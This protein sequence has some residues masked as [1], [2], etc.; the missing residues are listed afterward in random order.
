MASIYISN[1]KYTKGLSQ[2]HQPAHNN[3]KP[4]RPPQVLGLIHNSTT[5]YPIDARFAIPQ[6]L[7]VFT[8]SVKM[9]Q[10]PSKKCIHN[11]KAEC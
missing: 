4:F 9:T 3:K 2:L 10:R 11:Y 8:F 5:T 1:L 7:F 6:T